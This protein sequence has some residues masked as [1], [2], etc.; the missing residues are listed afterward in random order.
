M[1]GAGHFAVA[2]LLY[3]IATPA[4]YT[5]T[6]GGTQ[7]TVK[8]LRKLGYMDPPAPEDSIKSLMKDGRLQMKDKLGDMRENVDDMTDKLKDKMKDRVDEIKEKRKQKR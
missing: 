1:I 2:Y 7:L 4:R 5:L 3:K 6:L 8:Q